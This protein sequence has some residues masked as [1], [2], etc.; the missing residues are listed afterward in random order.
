MPEQK[1]ISEI[2]IE[3]PDGTQEP[4]EIYIPINQVD[5]LQEEL[6]ALKKMIASAEIYWDVKE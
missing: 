4:A 1:K 3:Y 2:V 6:D 5:Q